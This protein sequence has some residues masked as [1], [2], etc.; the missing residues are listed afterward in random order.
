[1]FTK[2][3]DFFKTNSPST[4]KEYYSP[5]GRREYTQEE[6]DNNLFNSIYTADYNTFTDM[7]ER[8]ANINKV[9]PDGSGR[10]EYT[11]S[12][13]EKIIYGWR[14]SDR[15]Q[16]KFLKYLFESGVNLF[17]YKYNGDFDTEEIDVYNAINKLIHKEYRQCVIDSLFMNYPDYMEEIELRNNTNKYNL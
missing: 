17:G 11:T 12:P 14:H 9:I 1:M 5:S 3:K 6:L 4:S 16:V 8:G 7:I 2:F 15:D 10:P 13:L